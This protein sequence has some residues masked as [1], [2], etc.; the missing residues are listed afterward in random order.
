MPYVLIIPNF[1]FLPLNLSQLVSDYSVLVFSQNRLNY[2]IRRARI[3]IPMPPPP[4]AV[5]SEY[6]LAKKPLG[7]RRKQ[8]NHG[9]HCKSMHSKS[10][11][12]GFML[13]R[14]YTYEVMSRVEHD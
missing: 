9:L 10:G 6:F 2:V 1:S 4:S 7:M 5:V 8:P 14:L 11:P 12:T 3:T 13:L